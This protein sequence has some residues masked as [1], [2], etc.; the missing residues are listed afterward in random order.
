MA[1]TLQVLGR[2]LELMQQRRFMAGS[3][4]WMAA[5]PSYP[6]YD[7]F[8]LYLP[9]APA[10]G[11]SPQQ[12][13]R[14][15]LYSQQGRRRGTEVAGQGLGDVLVGMIYSVLGGRLRD[16]PHLCSTSPSSSKSYLVR[17]AFP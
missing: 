15:S 13:Q 12:V 8:T 7:G 4:F 14:G 6:D 10:P 11:L 2:V 3:I 17:I 1:L 5:A 9:P 16:Q